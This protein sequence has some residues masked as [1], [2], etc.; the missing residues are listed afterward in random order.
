[1]EPIT[2]RATRFGP[3]PGPPTEKATL[4]LDPKLKEWGKHQAGGLSELVR[5]LMQ[6]EH[7]R[8]QAKN[9]PAPVRVRKSNAGGAGPSIG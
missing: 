3:V 5:R 7:D 2:E 4:L 8:Q 6:D 1:M 9:D